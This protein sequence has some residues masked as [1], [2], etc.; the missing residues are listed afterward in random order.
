MVTATDADAA[1]TAYL[2]ATATDADAKA[3]FSSYLSYAA[4]ATTDAAKEFLK[5][6]YA[7]LSFFRQAYSL[8]S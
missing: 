4:A 6:A 8:M 5:G 2:A 7:P 1:A 3:L